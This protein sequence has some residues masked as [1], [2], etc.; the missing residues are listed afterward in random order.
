M[1]CSFVMASALG[2]HGLGA[3]LDAGERRLEVGPRHPEQPVVALFVAERF[4]HLRVLLPSAVG[5]G[6]RAVPFF[7]VS[8]RIP[9]ANHLEVAD[10]SSRDQGWGEGGVGVGGAK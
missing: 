3:H 4:F 9:G 10:F 1:K 6:P 8:P 7:R 2:R 5:I